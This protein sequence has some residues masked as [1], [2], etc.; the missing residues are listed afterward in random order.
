MIS[1]YKKNIM[2]KKLK[3]LD[4]FKTGSWI[5]VINPNKEE[6]N[7]LSKTFDLNPEML[8]DGLDE[9]ELPRLD[10]EKNSHYIYINTINTNNNLSTFLII[11]GENFLLTLCKEDTK[12]IDYILNKKIE[13]I[14]TQ[15]KKSTISLLF[16]NNDLLEKLVTSIVKI[17]Q[18]KKNTSHNLTDKDL[19]ALLNHEELLNTLS[20]TYT[21]TLHLYNKMIKQM[22]FVKQDLEYINDLIIESE[23]GLDVCLSSLKTISNLR[24]Y[25]SLVI[26]NKLNKTITV[27]TVFTI[28][29][30]IATSISGLYG[31]NVELP[32]QNVKY[33]FSY[34]LLFMAFIML[35]LFFVLK[36]KKII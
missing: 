26:S 30:S 17:V 23:E 22:D 2:D 34:I 8:E 29:I 32:F 3:R 19:N 4:S 16:L 15:K 1:Y 7:F 5:N 14:T 12:L 27:L 28:L 24:N 25:Y 31:M 9:N 13:F 20:S 36:R 33:I 18:T 35:L 6:L 10:Y 21:Y 11:V